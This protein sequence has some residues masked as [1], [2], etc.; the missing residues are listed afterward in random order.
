MFVK[1]LLINSKVISVL[2]ICLIIFIVLLLI[3]FL[4]IK[5]YIPFGGTTSISDRKNYKKRASNYKDD[6][7]YNENEFQMI[8][9]ENEENVYVSKKS[10]TPIKSI[11]TEEPLI[12]KQPNNK[13]LNITWLG[14]S[15]ILMNISGMNILIDPVF[16]DYTSPVSFVGPP[17]YSSLPIGVNDLPK[18]DI[19]VISHDHYDHLDYKTIKLID[20]KVDKYIVPLGV[21]NHLERWKV[22]SDKITNMAWWEE[23]NI[24]G[25]LIGCTPAC[26][27]SAR[28]MLDKYNTLWA[29]YV[30]INDNYKVF[31]SGDS[32]YDNHFKEINKKYG[33]FDLSLL[34]AG[35]YDVKWKSTHM[36]PEQSVQ[37]GFDLNSKVIMPIHNSSFVLSSHPWD[38]PLERFVIESEKKNIKY[39]TPMIGET[40]NYKDDLSTS[41]WWRNIN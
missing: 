28:T 41:K 31:I 15:T 9:K 11:P 7:F 39:I 12:I 10:V 24:N 23:I 3:V 8:Y 37:A 1:N 18:I 40:I 21:E 27:Y 6:K 22:S 5:L 34:D 17:R 25:L 33:D 2:V 13:E 19:V 4:F 20:N 26:H 36:I 32:G 16:S 14:H 35:Q 29:S 38:D 30:F